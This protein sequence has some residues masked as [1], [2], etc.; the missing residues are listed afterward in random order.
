M[1]HTKYSIRAGN[2]FHS[3]GTKIAVSRVIENND[4]DPDSTDNDM[5]ILKLATPLTFSAKIKPIALQ[6]SGDEVPE[7]TIA[8][9]SGWG[10]IREGNQD[11]PAA[12]RAVDVRVISHSD[13][14]ESYGP[15]MIS[16]HMLCA[17]TAGHD[18]CQ[19]DSGG[20]LATDDGKLIG[21]VS[22]GYGCAR[23]EYPG[24]YAKVSDM[25]EWIMNNK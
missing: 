8:Y 9:V 15:G 21:V 12:L 6:D 25:N 1:D 3:V 11:T 20:P 23:P 18:S 17:Q 13:C 7:R 5:A 2:T 14:V 16:T 24:V 10:A 22:W 4:Y 19:G